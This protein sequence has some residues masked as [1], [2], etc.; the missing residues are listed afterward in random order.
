MAPAG[1]RAGSCHTRAGPG[2]PPQTHDPDPDSAPG[3]KIYQTQTRYGSR[4]GDPQVN[5]TRMN[6]E[7]RIST[8]Q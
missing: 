5:P 3:L 6:K 1:F 8:R 4:R 2:S 7:G